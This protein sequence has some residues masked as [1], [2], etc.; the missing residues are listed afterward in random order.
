MLRTQRPHFGVQPK[1]RKT[2]RALSAEA[3]QGFTQALT[4]RSDMTLQEQIIIASTLSF[5]KTLQAGPLLSGDRGII[6]TLWRRDG[7]AFVYLR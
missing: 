4:S 2:S 5:P 1:W 3:P 6:L 7:K